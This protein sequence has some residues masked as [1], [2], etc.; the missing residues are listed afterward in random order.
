MEEKRKEKMNRRE[1]WI[2]EV[3]FS[4]HLQFQY[5]TRYILFQVSK[6]SCESVCVFSVCISVGVGYIQ[7]ES[8]PQEFDMR[9]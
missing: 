8:N 9:G 6:A 5:N 1:N 3:S 7:W 2:T 4:F